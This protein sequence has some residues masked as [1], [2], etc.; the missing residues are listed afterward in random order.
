MKWETGVQ[1]IMLASLSVIAVD[2]RGLKQ[3]KATGG[4][5]VERGIVIHIVAIHLSDL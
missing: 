1:L 2:A 5:R 3:V 4:D